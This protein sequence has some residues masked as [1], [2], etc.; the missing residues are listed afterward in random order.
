[1][2]KKKTEATETGLDELN[3]SLTNVTRRMQENKKILAIISVVVLAVIA[4]VLAYVY[5]FRNPAMARAN[6]TIGE[7]DLELAQGNDS[8]L[9]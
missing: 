3:D 5:F 8:P 6:D 7:A 2:S 9:W 4:L 1:M